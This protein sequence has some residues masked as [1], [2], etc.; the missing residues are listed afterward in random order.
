MDPQHALKG[1]AAGTALLTV[2]ALAVDPTPRA[3][4]GTLA[5]WGAAGALHEAAHLLAAAALSSAPALWPR[6]AWGV[7]LRHSCQVVLPTPGR[8][9]VV[10]HAGWLASCAVAVAV[11]CV[12]DAPAGVVVGVTVT[13]LEALW[14]DLMGCHPEVPDTHFCGNFGLLL[15]TLASKGKVL[16][17]LQRM[18]AITMMRGAQ[19]GGVVTY[20]PDKTG[21]G[22][23]GLRV[24]VVNGK[25]TNLDELVYRKMKR[26]HPAI[27]EAQGPRLYCGHTRFA[28]SSLVTMDGCHPH[29]WAPPQTVEVWDGFRTGEFTAARRNAEVFI[30]HNGDFDAFK[31]GAVT[32]HVG[33]IQDWLERVLGTPRPSSVDS[34]AIAGVMDILRTQGIWSYSVRY[35]FLFSCRRGDLNYEIPTNAEFDHVAAAFRSA[36]ANAVGQPVG[37]LVALRR[38][39]VAEVLEQFQRSEGAVLGMDEETGTLAPFVQGA[40]DAF[41]D[42]DL[43]YSVKTF[44]ANAKGSFGLCVSCSLDCGRQF[45]LAARGQTISV[46]FYPQLQLILYGSEQAAVQAALDTVAED[47][48][49]SVVQSWS[50]IATRLD[51][52]D[53]GGEICLLDWGDGR[54]SVSKHAPTV[55]ESVDMQGPK[56]TVTLLHESRLVPARFESRLVPLERN[57]LVL[58]LPKPVSDTVGH[59][60]NEIPKVL[61]AIEESFYTVE[62]LN[63]VTAATFCRKLEQRLRKSAARTT[64]LKPPNEVDVLITG[65]EVS[66]WVGE[67]F[68]G[69]LSLLLPGLSVRVVSSNKL[70][71]LKGQLLPHASTGHQANQHWDLT[72]CIA[73]ILSHSGGTFAPLAVSNLLQPLTN[74]I[75]VV[76]SQWDT[77]VG[78]Q[79]RQSQWF[80]CIFSTNCG[81]RSAEPCSLTV[82]AMHH[83]LTGLLIFVMRTVLDK[84]LTQVA[85]A[86]YTEMD[87]HQ[88][89]VNYVGTLKAL[90]DIVGM[91]AA[92]VPRPT[93]TSK[94]IRAKGKHWADHVIEAPIC[95]LLMFAY[96]LVTVGLGYPI[97]SGIAMACGISGRPLYGTQFA[98]AIIYILIPQWTPL[99]VRL[100][101]RRPFWHRNSCR[102]VVIGDVPW[103][104][105]S[106]EAFLSKLFAVTYNNT[107][108]YVWSANPADHL[109][110][111]FTHRIVR[112]VLLACGRPDGRLSALTATENSVCL[113][114]NQASSIQNLR[115][116]C[117]TLTIGHNPYV[118][119][120]SHH[121]IFLHGNRPDYLCERLLKEKGGKT[122]LQGKSSAALT[123]LYSDLYENEEHEAAGDE[124]GRSSQDSGRSLFAQTLASPTF[125][126]FNKRKDDHIK[127]K[128]LRAMAGDTQRG[129]KYFGEFLRQDNPDAA[130]SQLLQ[131]QHL[132]MQLYESRIASQERLVAFFVLF[133][134]MARKVQQFWAIVSFG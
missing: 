82:V 18:V 58:P 35:S 94:L 103:V 19:S 95:W 61:K 110:H 26:Q 133:H 51:L 14:T 72:D 21:T 107:S 38:R 125:A 106:A 102:S 66:L 118:M 114:I 17:T 10:R 64:A 25:R 134:A 70:L 120:L 24:R 116:T 47:I 79:L 63:R 77:Q 113:S 130:P 90:E 115:T 54:P 124:E 83:L 36:F 78:K 104:A 100:V 85:L 75:F 84:K 13:A 43:L 7:L 33:A 69:D 98:D 59:D 119:P 73:L 132:S 15:L 92:A 42:N 4:L 111:R 112:G 50:Q 67:Q 37:D 93:E 23:K 20:V 129:E 81:L 88:L 29:Q 27:T 65:C 9:A 109:V 55:C 122:A 68:A 52:D 44:L 80:P 74:T 28:T 99:L 1:Y 12:Q 11:Y 53:L 39:V 16:T 108:V 48:G 41:F 117:E 45:V 8:V 121:A 40:V 91:D 71:A 6:N 34:A 56:V 101:Q 128:T 32:F 131:S 46:A 3:V 57:P 76:S 31:V 49:V 86:Q 127:A 89:E 2:V 60:I 87:I 96:I 97:I 126:E 5:A 30:C 22:P 105:Q 62:G 123:E